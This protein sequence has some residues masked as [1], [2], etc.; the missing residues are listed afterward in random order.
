MNSII[1]ST[2]AYANIVEGPFIAIIETVIIRAI[3]I[4]NY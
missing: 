4:K 1:L 2:L 3:K